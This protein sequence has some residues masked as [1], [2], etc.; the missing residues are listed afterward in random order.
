MH[1]IL[2]QHRSSHA[3]NTFGYVFH[4]VRQHPCLL[5]F[6]SY[7]LSPP[8]PTPIPLAKT[9]A[10]MAHNKGLELGADM[11]LLLGGG[12]VGAEITL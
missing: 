10:I 4:R 9:V 1:R 11:V 3:P 12:G 2:Q 8:P 7:K 5:C 6:T